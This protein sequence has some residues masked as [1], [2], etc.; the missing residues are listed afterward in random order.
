MIKCVIPLRSPDYTNP[1]HK[2]RLYIYAVYTI[3]YKFALYLHVYL[4]AEFTKKKISIS[5]LFQI[6]MVKF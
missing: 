6:F 4:K 3:M 2:I 1:Q 5:F